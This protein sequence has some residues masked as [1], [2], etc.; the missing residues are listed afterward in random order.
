MA[1]ISVLIISALVAGLYLATGPQMRKTY[2]DLKDLDWKSVWDSYSNDKI[3]VLYRTNGQT[4]AT[5][6]GTLV[7]IGEQNDQL[8]LDDIMVWDDDTKIIGSAAKVRTADI[9]A[10]IMPRRYANF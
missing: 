6:R 1:I 4:T 7:G 8:T 3:I 5:M 9:E 2:S 10:L